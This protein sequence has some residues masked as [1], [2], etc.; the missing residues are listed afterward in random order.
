M[1]GVQ[2]DAFTMDELTEFVAESIR[3][4]ARR[5]I[6][7]HNLHSVYLYQTDPRMRTFYA[8][9]AATFVDGMALIGIA[10]LLRV[11][12]SRRHR[13][14]AID[15]LHPLLDRACA[16]GWRVFVLAGAP[17]L[18][19]RAG[20]ILEARHP[21]LQ[22]ETA[23]GFFNAERESGDSRD[24]LARIRAFRPQILMVGMG[25]PRQERWIVEHLADIEANAIL[26][27]GCLMEYT[28]GDIPTPP[29]WLGQCGL[30]WCFRLVTTPR[31]VARR[32]LVES[33]ALLPVF[34]REWRAGLGVRR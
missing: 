24:V 8:R 14:A 17:G 30:E 9:A 33:W 5:I 21:G 20:R 13:T 6:A 25:M 7:N 28:A 3:A 22:M 27:V 18:G 10:R 26:N 4:Q 19:E 32:Y 1:L 23:H 29:R 16:E 11:P 15:W 2:V 12:L 31:R 34:L